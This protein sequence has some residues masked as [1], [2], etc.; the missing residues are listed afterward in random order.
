M[1]RI[2]LVLV[3][4]LL[5]FSLVACSSYDVSLS[6]VKIIHADETDLEFDSLSLT[7]LNSFDKTLV[8]SLKLSFPD[9]DPITEEFIIGP[10]ET[11]NLLFEVALPFGDYGIA[12]TTSCNPSKE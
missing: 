1:K 3:L 4:C 2:S 5:L 8:C 12:L 9:D 11:K 6:N 7:A 10:N